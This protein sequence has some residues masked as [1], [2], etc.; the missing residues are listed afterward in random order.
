MEKNSCYFNYIDIDP[1]LN[2]HRFNLLIG[3]PDCSCTD[4]VNPSGIGFCKKTYSCAD[5]DDPRCVKK[6]HEKYVCYVNQ[7]TNCEDVT[8]SQFSK[9]KKA[10]AVACEKE[11][12]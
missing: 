11:K 9:G 7:P 2:I 3:D 12:G 6:F 4:F 10:S 1:N 8:N 5:L